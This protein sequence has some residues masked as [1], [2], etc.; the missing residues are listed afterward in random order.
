MIIMNEW[1]IFGGAILLISAIFLNLITL[2]KLRT[3]ESLLNNNPASQS[4]DGQYEE[5]IN[6]LSRQYGLSDKERE[7]ARQ[8]YKGKNNYEIAEALSVAE[9]TVKSHNYR[10]YRKLGV[11]NRVQAVNLIR[12]GIKP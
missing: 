8:L 7:I 11:E 6:E 3:I 9:N 4:Q 10:L 5:R 2:V 1:L 12:E